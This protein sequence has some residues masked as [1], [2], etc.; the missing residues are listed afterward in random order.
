MCTRMRVLPSARRKDLIDN[1]LE[2]WFLEQLSLREPLQEIPECMLNDTVTDPSE[3][4]E[5]SGGSSAPGQGPHNSADWKQKIIQTSTF[6]NLLCTLL[7][8]W[9]VTCKI[10]SGS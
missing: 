5:P 9:A 3:L 2:D 1:M 6:R 4:K 10:V 8:L 7:Y